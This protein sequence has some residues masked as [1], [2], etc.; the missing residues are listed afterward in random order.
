MNIYKVE[1]NWNNDYDTYDSFVCIAENEQKARES[2]PSGFVTHTKDG[3]WYGTYTKGGEYEIIGD[4]WVRFED[5]G[6][7]K[8]TLIGVANVD[9]NREVVCASFNAG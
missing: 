1:Q 8:V 9:Q 2:Y 4:N 5:I 3:K 7:L 6:K